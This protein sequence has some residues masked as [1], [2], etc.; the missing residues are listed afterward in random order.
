[1]YLYYVYAYIRSNSKTPYYIGKGK[2]YR[3]WEN[4]VEFLFQKINLKL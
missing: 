3:A 1:M 4:I 2:N